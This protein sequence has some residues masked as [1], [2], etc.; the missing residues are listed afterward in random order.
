MMQARKL[1]LL[2]VGAIQIGLL[3]LPMMGSPLRADEN[4]LRR[5]I[6]AEI[7]ATWQR[8]KVSPS[9]TANDSEFLR[10]VS[11]DLVGVVPTYEETIAYLQDPSPQKREALVDRLLADQRYAQHQADIWDLILFGRHPPGHDTDKREGI[12]RWLRDQFSRNR[13]YDQWVQELLKAE[14]NSVEQGPPIY[15]AQYRNQPEDLTEVVTQTFLGVQLQCAR[16]HDHPFESWKQLDF[17]GVAGFF[18]RLQIVEV[19][20]KDN[21]T[22][23]ALAEKNSGDV[24]FTGPA[25]EQM[26]GKKGEPVAP[27]FLSGDPLVEPPLPEGFKETKVENNKPPPA[28]FFSRKDQFAAWVT[29]ADNP[30]F[31]R[32][33]ANRLW[34]QHFGRGLVHPVDNMSASNSPSHPALLDALAGWLV[35]HRFDLRG[36]IREMV[37]SNTY[38]LSSRG[39]TGES[40][41]QWFQH[42]RTRP[43]S[44]EEL[45]ESWRVVTNYDATVK[46]KPNEKRGQRF[47]PLTGDYVLRFFGQ[48]TNGTGDFQGGL[49]EHLYLNNGQLGS[50]LVT[51]P[52]G[53][54]AEL[55]RNEQSW[56]NRVERLFLQVLNRP[57]ATEEREKMIELLSA[58]KDPQERLRDVIWALMTCSEF[59]FNH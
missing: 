56:D 32:A 14:G 35:E 51:A 58:E 19:G 9:P 25:K 45:A 40:L 27:K 30:Y 23:Y 11:L 44:A 7:R 2:I 12:Q 8:E 49:A 6:D 1:L 34:A 46:D 37:L 26:P 47:R 13:P 36:A 54:V 55:A 15:Y 57:P 20:K 17:Y 16:C 18:A 43:L 59:R 31:S 24:L 10:R 4:L 38:G 22:L 39:T 21:L 48:P 28:P 52:G 50:L 5:V 41:P 29:R 53:L 33:I 3:V 42:A